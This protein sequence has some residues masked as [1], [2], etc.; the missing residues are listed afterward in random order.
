MAHLKNT[1]LKVIEKYCGY[2]YVQKYRGIIKRSSEEIV[3]I[4]NT[5]MVSSGKSSLF[6]A[7]IGSTE[8][9]QFPTGAAR[10]TTLADYYDCGN[11]SFVDTPGIDVRDEDDELAF[12]TIMEADV[13]IMVH[14]IRTGPLNRSE[15]EWLAKL[16]EGMDDI[17]TRKARLIFVCTWKDTRE[18]DD[19]YNDIINNVKEEVFNLVGAEIPFFDV[20]VKKYLT[21]V[22]KKQRVLMDNS[23]I[24]C[25]KK[26]LED[27]AKMFL[28]SK[29]NIE[30]KELQVLKEEMKQLLQEQWMAKNDDFVKVKKRVSMQYKARNN[31]WEQVFHYFAAKREQYAELINEL[32]NM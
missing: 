9:E 26:Y 30:K 27:Y 10:T 29:H 1:D 5:G 20:S 3:R 11:I 15:V 16:I 21:G 28:Q 24:A 17:E 19:D 23:S 2:E 6:N 12:S 8:N 31:A 25:L 4:V 18:K 22:A 14:N 13:I 32:N 7:L